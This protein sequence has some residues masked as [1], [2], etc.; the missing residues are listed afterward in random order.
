MTL[1][2]RLK[3]LFQ[4]H[5]D[6]LPKNEDK[7]EDIADIRNYYTHYNPDR[8]QDI[9]HKYGDARTA[10][11]RYEGLLHLLLLATVYKE[12]GIPTDAIKDAMFN[13]DSRFGVS[14]ERLFEG[15]N[16]D[17]FPY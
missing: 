12:I 13:A 2:I 5:Q 8:Q 6:V 4:Y 16:K 11:N 7:S 3:D 9:E 15:P 10:V 1:R 17:G 14:S